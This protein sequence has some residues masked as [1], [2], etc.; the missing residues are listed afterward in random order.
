MEKW[1]MEALE[2]LYQQAKEKAAE[3]DAFRTLMQENPQAA[4]EK[5]AG[6]ALSGMQELKAI[7]RA[8][9]ELN[10]A[11]IENVAGGGQGEFL[12]EAN[13]G[14][15]IVHACSGFQKLV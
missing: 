11:A 10:D 14:G 15:F 6:C 3:D 8:P 4:L 7:V 12:P 2:K 5:L 9:A 13:C 1:T